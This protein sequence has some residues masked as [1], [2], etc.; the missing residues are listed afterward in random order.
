[1]LMLKLW[2]MA[3][4]MMYINVCIVMLLSTSTKA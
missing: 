2:K 3:T 1:M 4:K